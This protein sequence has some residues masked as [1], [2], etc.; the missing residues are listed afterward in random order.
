MTG[1]GR[2]RR[3]GLGTR[4]TLIDTTQPEVLAMF[5]ELYTVSLFEE[6]HRTLEADR[7]REERH[8]ERR[9]ALLEALAE[10]ASDGV[11]SVPP[12]DRAGRRRD[13]GPNLGRGEDLHRAAGAE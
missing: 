6:F 11:A 7:R 10:P 4:S 1:S 2:Y 3:Y 9:A 12:R 8:A 5:L 13:T